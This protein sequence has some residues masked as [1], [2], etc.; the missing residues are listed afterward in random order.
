MG[1]LGQ[2]GLVLL[3][4]RAGVKVPHQAD[5]DTCSQPFTPSLRDAHGIPPFTPLV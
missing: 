2:R 4:G 3:P 5:K 1:E